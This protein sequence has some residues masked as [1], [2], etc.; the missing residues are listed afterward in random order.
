MFSA[1]AELL[2]KL[3]GAAGGLPGVRRDR[4]RKAI[5]RTML[6]DSR[7]EWRSI[8]T[9]ARSIGASEEK[10]RELLISIGGRASAQGKTE[11]WGLT[12][13]VGSS[14]TK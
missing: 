6:Q 5:L 8:S 14:G 13:R 10:T 12:S 9:L 2:S 3:L 7:F 11:L 1:I 4:K